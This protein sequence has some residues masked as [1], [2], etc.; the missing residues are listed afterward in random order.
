[1]ASILD[2]P[3]VPNF[4]N[5]QIALNNKKSLDIIYIDYAGAFD[6]VV[7]SK[8]L[9]KLKNYEIKYDLFN[10][11][12]S[13]LQNRKQCFFLNNC[14]SEFCDVYIFIVYK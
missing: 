13:F 8:L 3:R 5:V 9:L 2:I 1:M 10:W 6:A 11:I 14:S 7:H 12:L 4:W